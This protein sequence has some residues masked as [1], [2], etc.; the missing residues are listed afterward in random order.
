MGAAGEV[1][2]TSAAGTIKRA[3]DGKKGGGE[4]VSFFFFP[5]PF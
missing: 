4:S 1:H 2:K 5:R 3:G